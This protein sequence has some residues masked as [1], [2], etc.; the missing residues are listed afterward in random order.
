MQMPMLK[1]FLLN[2]D[3]DAEANGQDKTLGANKDLDHTIKWEWKVEKQNKRVTN[4]SA[5][6]QLFIL[7]SFIRTEFSNNGKKSNIVL[8]S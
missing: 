6:E 2:A 1:A 4:P 5:E 8:Y 3:V 7:S